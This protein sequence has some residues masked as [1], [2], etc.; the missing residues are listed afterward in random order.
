MSALLDAAKIMHGVALISHNNPKATLCAL[1]KNLCCGP[2]DSTKLPPGYIETL[3]EMGWEWD[4]DERI[5]KFYT[6]HG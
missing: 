2:C 1:D 6:G 4:E 5:W 3:E